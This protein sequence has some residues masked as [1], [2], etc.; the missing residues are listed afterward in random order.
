MSSWLY[1][2]L[3]TIHCILD[4]RINDFTNDDTP[5]P[6]DHISCMKY[7]QRIL[8]IA[9][10]RPYVV[11]FIPEKT[12]VGKIIPINSILLLA[13]PLFLNHSS[14]LLLQEKVEMM[15]EYLRKGFKERVNQMDW[16]S[17]LSK[18]SS[19]EKVNT[20]TAHSAYPEE[21]NNSDYVS[22]FYSE[23]SKLKRR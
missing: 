20:I 5:V 16:L 7:V 21:I 8:P 19:I 14:S 18:Q 6:G 3:A 11:N 2:I 12:K 15:V 22:G 4:I 9:L 1:H 13:L 17:D 10:A 23:V